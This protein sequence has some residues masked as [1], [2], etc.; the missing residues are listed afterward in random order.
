M[1]IESNLREELQD[2]KDH[3][4]RLE[5]SLNESEG[6]QQLSIEVEFLR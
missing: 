1:K 2:S 4:L 6:A 5:S 3:C